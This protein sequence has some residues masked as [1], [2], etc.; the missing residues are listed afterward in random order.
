M[1]ATVSGTIVAE[2]PE[3]ELVGIEGNHYFPPSSLKSEAFTK[4]DTQYTCP[5]K[6]HA[7]YWNVVV[8]GEVH[9]DAAWSYPEPFDGSTERVGH[10]FA[11]YVAFDKSQVSIG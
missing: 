10:D 5:W 8:D 11:G 7:Q 9:R 4:S 2:T 3:S 6:G 1:Q